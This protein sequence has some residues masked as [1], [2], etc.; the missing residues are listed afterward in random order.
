MEVAKNERGAWPKWK[1]AWPVCQGGRGLGGRGMWQKEW[2]GAWPEQKG[3]WP[4]RKEAWPERKEAWP[5]CQGGCGLDGSVFKR[6]VSEME[7]GV[8]R[9]EMG[10]A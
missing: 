9:T 3:A 8:A 1:G 7:G 4:E 2:K 6:G 10:V 5:V